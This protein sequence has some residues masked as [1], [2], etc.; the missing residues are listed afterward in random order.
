MRRTLE[1]CLFVCLI[2]SSVAAREKFTVGNRARNIQCSADNKSLAI[3]YCY[4][5]AE[6]RK[7]VGI[8]IGL[9]VLTALDKPFYIQGILSVKNSANIYHKMIDSSQ[10]EMC[11]ILNGNVDNPWI[12]GTV[13]SLKEAFPDIFH[14][15]PYQEGLVE[16]KNLTFDLIERNFIPNGFYK[17]ELILFKSSEEIGRLILFLENKSQLRLW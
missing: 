8:Y 2:S 6:S 12:S 13:H 4:L 16:F 15:C 14:V 9:N 5:K 11:S 7:I 17:L 3:S 10:K 1:F